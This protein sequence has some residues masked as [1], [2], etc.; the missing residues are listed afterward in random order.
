MTPIQRLA[1]FLDI[2][3][4]SKDV[5]RLKVHLGGW[6]R[7]NEILLLGNVCSPDLRR[8]ILLEVQ[9]KGRPD[10][11]RKLATRLASTEQEE[12][13]EQINACLTDRILD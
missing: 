12:L 6:N 8:L 9:G 5:T 13:W 11:L 4:S 7:L 1:K 3:M 10:I 2:S